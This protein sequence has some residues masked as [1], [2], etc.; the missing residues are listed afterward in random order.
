MISNSAPSTLVNKIDDLVRDYSLD[1]IVSLVDKSSYN[2]SQREIIEAIE[3]GT[4]EKGLSIPSPYWEILTLNDDKKKYNLIY[5]TDYADVAGKDLGKVINLELYKLI[6]PKSITPS[7]LHELLSLQDNTI[8]CKLA[9]L[10]IASLK[11][12]F[13]T[14]PK[15]R[16]GFN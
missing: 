5:L 12:L 6:D 4:L 16:S 1:E 10:D 8:I 13:N 15:K 7:L 14:I 9:N 3:N 2:M 11:I